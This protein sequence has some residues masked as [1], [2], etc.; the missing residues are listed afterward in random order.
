MQTICQEA[1]DRQVVR[2]EPPTTATPLLE[3]GM[4]APMECPEA[5]RPMLAALIRAEVSAQIAARDRQLL[6]AWSRL[7]SYR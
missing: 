6:R 7:S 1:L 5:M 2:P 4:A 3:A